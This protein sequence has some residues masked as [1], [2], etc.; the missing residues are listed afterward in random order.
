[1]EADWFCSNPGL[2]LGLETLR[3]ASQ[4]IHYMFKT[5]ESDEGD[6]SR[7]CAARAKHVGQ[8]APNKVA[9]AYRQVHVVVRV[10]IQAVSVDECGR[11]YF[12]QVSK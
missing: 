12:S 8:L 1:M 11:K 2:G 4:A 10:A 6:P 7:L 5:L 3:R 9:I